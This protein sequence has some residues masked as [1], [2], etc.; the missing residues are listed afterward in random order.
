MVSVIR[1]LLTAA[2]FALVTTGAFSQSTNSATDPSRIFRQA[3]PSVVTVRADAAAESRQGSAVAVGSSYSGEGQSLKAT[4][5]WFATNAH[6]VDGATNGVLVQES[7]QSWPA[8]VEYLDERPDLALL[9]A[10]K[11]VLPILK[12]IAAAELE[13]GSKVFAIGSPLGLERTL[14]AAKSAR[15][16]RLAWFTSIHLS[17]I[18]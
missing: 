5:T 9:Y 12:P 8:K 16:S 11:L 13:V 4:G 6:V 15:I 14:S 3:S 7:G 1:S 10:P 18:Q 17:T 2:S